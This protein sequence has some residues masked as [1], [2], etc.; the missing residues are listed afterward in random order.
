VN[1]E[2]QTQA[3]V[4]ISNNIEHIVERAAANTS[5]AAETTRVANYLRSVT[6]ADSRGN[7]A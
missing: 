7:V 1:T 4:E 5:V 3:T 6:C 2:Q